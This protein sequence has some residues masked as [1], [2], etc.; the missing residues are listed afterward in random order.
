MPRIAIISTNKELARFFELELSMLGYTCEIFRTL[1]SMPSE[2]Y[3]FAF[4]DAD[5]EKLSELH[6][7]DC[8]FAIIT[9]D[10]VSISDD[11]AK[12]LS[13][14]IPI[15]QISEAC[16][17]IVQKNKN[18]PTP[19]FGGG[20]DILGTLYVIDRARYTVA[21]GNRYIKLS[22]NEFNVLELLCKSSGETV[23]RERISELLGA[24]EGNIS[25]VYICNIRKKLESDGAQ[26]VI[27]TVRGRGYRT[28]LRIVE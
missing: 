23:A 19:A 1:S 18:A 17:E 8:E 21:M 12:V 15:E 10:T 28:T 26:R 4:V 22:K 20:K 16:M 27:F 9:K 14:P 6:S 13:W 2:T 7:V 3:D 24:E 5:T 11:D 25:D